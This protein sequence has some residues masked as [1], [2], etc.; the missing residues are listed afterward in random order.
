MTTSS[1]MERP[2]SEQ[3]EEKPM[4][5]WKDQPQFTSEDKPIDWERE[6]VSLIQLLWK[7]QDDLLKVLKQKR[8]YIKT[9]DFEK[10]KTVETLEQSVLKRLQD[11]YTRRESLLALAT[12]EG[13]SVENLSQL[14]KVVSKNSAP[15]LR[16]QLSEASM[17]MRFLQNECL[18]NWVLAQRSLLHVSQLLEIIS[19]G[20]KEKSTYKQGK[21][22]Q[23][24]TA[25][26][27]RGNLL[28]G[29]A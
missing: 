17:R 5:P 27:T 16:N 6:V 29:A 23:A 20:G 22:V 25:Y 1:T 10:C 14:A 11:C 13:F 2:Q 9:G 7:V 8:E 3:R 26:A 18:T 24:D 15:H 19:S 4:T 28:D 12:E 21:N